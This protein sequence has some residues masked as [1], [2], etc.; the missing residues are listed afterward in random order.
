MGS[1]SSLSISSLLP[2]L[3]T[4]IYQQRQS[5]YRL[6]ITPL[7]QGNTFQKIK[8][9]VANAAYII[10]HLVALAVLY[11]AKGLFQIYQYTRNITSNSLVRAARPIAPPIR[12]PSPPLGVQSANTL[13][14]QFILLNDERGTLGVNR[15]GTIAEDAQKVKARIE[16]VS[17]ELLPHAHTEESYQEMQ[18]TFFTIFFTAMD[19]HFDGMDMNSVVGLR[20]IHRT[21]KNKLVERFGRQLSVSII[22]LGPIGLC[23]ALTFY[24]LGFKVDCFE[25]REHDTSL[26]QDGN[27]SGRGYA[28]RSQPFSLSREVYM[29]L[30]GLGISY[31]RIFELFGEPTPTLNEIVNFKERNGVPD[32]LIARHNLQ[33]RKAQSPM[34]HTSKRE[35]IGGKAVGYVP[36]ILS[37]RIKDTQNLFYEALLP[38]IDNEE[39]TL[40]FSNKLVKVE[41]EEDHHQT[42]LI[43]NE[44]HENVKY[45][46]DIIY[47]ASGGAANTL[48]GFQQN[49]LAEYYGIGVF[50]DPLTNV[51]RSDPAPDYRPLLSRA[52]RVFASRRQGEAIY[53]GVELFRDEFDNVEQQKS[54]VETVRREFGLGEAKSFFRVPVHIDQ[55][56]TPSKCIA[57]TNS[58]IPQ[59]VLCAGDALTKPHFLTASG[60]NI[61]LLGLI[62]L[63]NDLERLIN[64][65]PLADP[66]HQ[67]HSLQQVTDK[68]NT[69]ARLLQK[70]VCQVVINLFARPLK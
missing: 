30:Q 39:L 2:S 34:M 42:L 35:R 22:G 29:Y 43:E 66:L 36:N 38:C 67:V 54:L 50:F 23:A 44:N 15:R 56:Q 52:V 28:E 61:G 16:R 70:Q 63:N 1:T 48:L 4:S 46:P 40:H 41:E 25:Q 31:D 49:R 53:C 9:T 37:L 5:I 65:N 13:R 45:T 47:N 32:E 3:E 18:N 64:P 57:I 7:N 10:V 14:S 51:D 11:P 59:L 68:Y 21:N 62:K 33:W 8:E 60:A 27:L 58:P 24:R 6:Y 26:N 69:T 17:R 20:S 55:V 19:S 12:L